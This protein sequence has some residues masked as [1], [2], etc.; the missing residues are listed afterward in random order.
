MEEEST[1]KRFLKIHL[2]LRDQR[3]KTII[4]VCVCIYMCVCVCVCVCIYIYKLLSKHFMVIAN[5][6]FTKIYIRKRNPNIT[7]KIIIKSQENK[8]R[9]G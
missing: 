1:N 8:K 5:Q 7:L 6:K 2:K 9:T 3:L 4:C